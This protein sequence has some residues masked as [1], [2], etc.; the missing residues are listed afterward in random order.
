[1]DSRWNRNTVSLVSSVTAVVRL[2]I[3][4]INSMADWFQ[5]P[6]VSNA[7][8]K[9]TCEADNALYFAILLAAALLAAEPA[10]LAV[11]SMWDSA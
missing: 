5:V 7:T 1:M 9:K 10:S 2:P 6:A 11:W 4:W 8:G 3:S